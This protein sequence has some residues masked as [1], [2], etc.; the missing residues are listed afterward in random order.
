LL[1]I[2][3]AAIWISVAVTGR[4]SILLGV[5]VALL[6]AAVIVAMLLLAF[7]FDTPVA[8]KLNPGPAR[9]PIVKMVLKTGILGLLFGASYT[10]AGV[11]A[12]RQARGTPRG[13]A[14][15]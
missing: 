10:L 6:V 8:L 15:T 2:G 5:G 7:A 4:K 3:I 1:S 13:E 9:E 11:L 12:L 14:R